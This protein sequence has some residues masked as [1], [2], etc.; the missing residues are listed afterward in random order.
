[1]N[2][3][4]EETEQLLAEYRRTGDRSK[5]NEVVECHMRMARF[6]V[7]RLARGD[8]E[9][10]EDLHQVALLAIVR[11]ADRYRPGMGA[12]FR[13]FAARTID[14]ELKR[15]LRDKTWAVRPPRTRQE[16]FLHVCKAREAL[17]QELG[18]VPTPGEI[19]ERT[20]LDVD[21]VLDAIE[22]G[23]SRT[24]YPLEPTRDDADPVAVRPEMV[25]FDSGYASF[26]SH[27]DLHEAIGTL[28]DR[29]C[30]VLRLRFVHELSQPEIAERLSISQSYVSRIIRGALAK[31]REEMDDDRT[32]LQT[33]VPA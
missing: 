23:G 5:R 24:S 12:S 2:Q 4:V 14:G 8:R 15:H 22:A 9:L 29:Q 28:D 18:R 13:T 11:A 31:L 3:D 19:A 17:G 25:R 21:A 32:T 6:T 27:R 10:T 16:H 33:A 20:G 26:D 7:R 1:M 30:D